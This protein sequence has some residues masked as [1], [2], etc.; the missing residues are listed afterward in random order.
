[1]K[2]CRLEDV[3]CEFG[4]VRCDDRFRREVGPLFFRD[5]GKRTEFAE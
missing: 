3:E 4:G 2:M 1:M 5:R